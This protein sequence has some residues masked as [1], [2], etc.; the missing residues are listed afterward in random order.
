MNKVYLVC[1]ALFAFAL[2]AAPGEGHK[3]Y[4]RAELNPFNAP[5]NGGPTPAQRAK[6][7]LAKM[8]QADKLLMVHG[9]D[10]PYVGDVPA[11]A[12]LKIPAMT[13]EDG[14]QGVADGVKLVTAF[15]SALT[16]VATWDVDL[17]HQYGIT[18][19]EE[20]FAKGTNV[21]LGPMVNIARVPYGGRNFESFGEDPHLSSEMAAAQIT[22]V[23][24]KGIIATVKHFVDNNQ[25][26][27]RTTVSENVPERA[28]WE[29]YYPAFH[30]AVEVGVGSVMCAY[31]KVNNTYSCENEQTLNADLKGTMGFQG[32]VMSDWGATHSTVKA[33]NAGLD[34]QMPDDSFFGQALARAV[35]SGQV[36][37]ARL[38]DMVLRMLTPMFAMGIMDRPAS[39]NLNIN[40]QSAAH[41][42]FARKVAQEANVLLKNDGNLLPLDVT[43]L[44]KIAVIGEDASTNPTATGDGS[45]HVIAPYIITPLQAIQARVGNQ[46][47]VLYES[48]NTIKAQSIARA[49]DVAIVFVAT[50]SSEGVDRRTLYLSEEQNKLVMAVRQA[51]PKTVVVIH[52]PGALCLPWAASVPSIISAFL[53]GQEDGN[54]IAPVL[55]GDVNPSGKLPLTWPKNEQQIPVNTV[56]QYPGV[57]DEADYSENLLVGYRWYDAKNVAPLFEFGRGLSY[58]TFEYSALRITGTE[59]QGWKIQFELKN[60]G[61]VN[62][63]EVPQFYLGFP[64]SAG[65]PPKV[66]RGFEKI[67]LEAGQFKQVSFHMSRQGISIWS[68]QK[69]DWEVITG[70]FFVY[71]GSSSRDIRLHGSFTV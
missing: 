67:F 40:V 51:Q 35:A 27:N 58:T 23:Q 57:H 50:D 65:E 3:T 1:I 11:I 29:I 28:Q 26:Y 56:K 55:F 24:S 18:L 63:A 2:F 32:W 62:G 7:L 54:G 12:R 52:T 15:P 22:G 19:A 45:G 46:L 10:G 8:T 20:Q 53:P 34:Q 17:M 36:S 31:N 21:M 59:S 69:H 61:K 4:R 6:E 41:T 5:T 68:V 33:A 39:G 48:N 66:L 38:D 16:A 60:S 25:E 14:P 9:S 47:T 42:K 30:A 71:I 64:Q 49:S 70:T 43:K 44:K 13:L 37:Q